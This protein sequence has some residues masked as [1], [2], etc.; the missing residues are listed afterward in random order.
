MMWLLRG[1]LRLFP[2]AFRAQFGA[3]M[4]EQIEHDY[5]HARERGRL[6]AIGFVLM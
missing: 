3:E 2:A 6:T 1:M 5:A 4:G